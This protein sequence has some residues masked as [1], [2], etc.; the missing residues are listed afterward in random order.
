MAYTWGKAFVEDYGRR[1][2]FDYDRRHAL[3]VVGTW[4]LTS[5]VD[6]GATLR[7]ASG[8]PETKP[9]G[10]TV[11]ANLAPG[12]TPHAPGSLIPARDE[13]GTLIWTIDGGGVA[14]LNNSRLP[15][16]ARLDLRVTYAPSRTSRWQ[17][18]LE[19]INALNRDNAGQLRTSLQYD[20]ASDRPT[21]SF[22][23]DEGLPFLPSFGLRLRF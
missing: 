6:L 20:P 2:P 22:V 11:A 5:K 9:L 18:Y 3:S 13:T 12:A 15:V 4:R 10:V 8:F 23:R 1:Y 19:A 7:V 21:L 16:F 14:N 17:F